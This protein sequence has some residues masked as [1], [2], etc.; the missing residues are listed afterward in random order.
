MVDIN[1]QKLHD[2]KREIRNKFENLQAELPK[3]REL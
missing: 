1:H 2:I 3:Y